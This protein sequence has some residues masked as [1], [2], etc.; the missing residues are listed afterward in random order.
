MT[1]GKC[2]RRQQR[3]E[4]GAVMGGK[5]SCT[6]GAG[7]SVERRTELTLAV[8][9]L[10]NARYTRSITVCSG[11]ESIFLQQEGRGGGAVRV[12][13]RASDCGCG[14]WS[15]DDGGTG[16]V[17]AQS[18]GRDE[19]GHGQQCNLR[20]E[21]ML[22]TTGHTL[23]VWTNRGCSSHGRACASQV[24]GNGIDTHLLQS[25]LTFL[26]PLFFPHHLLSSRAAS[27]LRR[28]AARDHIV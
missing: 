13:W 23:S 12:W 16:T 4:V 6:L 28:D 19:V 3:D 25:K 27:R 2:R 15:V 20:G 24:Q 1:A 14:V 11:D 26:S 10:L 5:A 8:G 7:L 17:G 21:F 9:C 18:I 22:R